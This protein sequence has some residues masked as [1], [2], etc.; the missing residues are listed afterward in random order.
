MA[1]SSKAKG[2]KGKLGKNKHRI[3]AYY[4]SGNYEWNRMRRLIW[5]MR[6]YGG[7]DGSANLAFNTLR[8]ALPLAK[9]R[10]FERMYCQQS[11]A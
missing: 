11:A 5:H 10:M 7:N 6:S 3:A 4:S 1:G 9:Q 2:R 8:A